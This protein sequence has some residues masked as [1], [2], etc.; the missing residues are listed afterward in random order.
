MVR[1]SYSKISL[2]YPP[3]KKEGNGI[4]SI[5]NFIT[6]DRELVA[7]YTLKTNRIGSKQ[8]EAR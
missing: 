3:I 8:P 6:M 1:I 7:K 4:R 5:L 2:P